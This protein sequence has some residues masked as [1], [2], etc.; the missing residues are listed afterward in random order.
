MN[1]EIFKKAY[2][3]INNFTDKLGEVVYDA[4]NEE[5][6]SSYEMARY[7]IRTFKDCKT[8]REFDIADQIVTAICGWNFETLLER[9]NER[10]TDED[11]E[12]ESCEK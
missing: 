8:E 12:W 6:N 11:F 3:E 7:I 4:I 1:Q 10:D 9:I 2:N 5:D